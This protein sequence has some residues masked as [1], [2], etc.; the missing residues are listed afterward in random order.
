MTDHTVVPGDVYLTAHGNCYI[1]VQEGQTEELRELWVSLDPINLRS[2]R[3][4]ISLGDKFIFN[5]TALMRSLS[6][7]L[8]DKIIE[9]TDTCSY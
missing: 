5:C 9:G 3:A 4:F 6:D 2:G 7:K 1:I 8:R